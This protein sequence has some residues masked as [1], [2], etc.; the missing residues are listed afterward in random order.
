MIANGIL[1]RYLGN[2][3]LVTLN[4][5][6]RNIIMRE[7]WKCSFNLHHCTLDWIQDKLSRPIK[8]LLHGAQMNSEQILLVTKGDSQTM[9]KYIERQMVALSSLAKGHKDWRLRLILCGL[10]KRARVQ[11]H[12]AKRRCKNQA[13][14]RNAIDRS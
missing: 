6:I 14:N 7:M 10:H 3:F 4:T 13:K 8:W 11:A 1:V 12:A 2:N 9:K 5:M